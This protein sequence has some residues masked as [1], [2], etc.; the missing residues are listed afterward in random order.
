M[1][2]AAHPGRL[3][4]ALRLG[5]VS[6][7][8][9]VWSNVLAGIALGAAPLEPGPAA[10]LAAALSLSYVGGMYLND[11]F[12]AQWDAEHRAER[13]IPLGHARRGVV[14]VAGVAM[15]ASGAGL[16]LLHAPRLDVALAAAALSALIVAYDLFHKGNPV[17]P[18]MMG[19]CRVG[20]YACAALAS[21]GTLSWRWY[22]GAAVL[23]A[24]VVG[25]TFVARRESKDPGA[26]KRVGQLIAGIALLDAAVLLLTWHPVASGL[27]AGAFVL[28]RYWQRSVPGT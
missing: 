7:L 8:P 15:L 19:L 22:A 26:K 20:V 21:G 17:A 2:A 18:V 16:L 9:T 27:A 14:L 23:L 11:A 6:N 3:K 12:D 24:W 10:L 1:T 28:T 5:R 13:P 4:V 25:L